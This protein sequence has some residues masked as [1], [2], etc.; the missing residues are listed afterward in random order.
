ML[1]LVPSLWWESSSR[2]IVEAMI[3][4]IPIIATNRG[5]ISETLGKCG[6][7]INLNSKYCEKPYDKFL[8]ENE[9]FGC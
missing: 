7:L 2:V 6:F 1:V 3:N 9:M 5:G 8:Q 4:S